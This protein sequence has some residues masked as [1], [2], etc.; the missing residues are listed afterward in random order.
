MTARRC[1]LL[2]ATALIG[3]V[4]AASAA[5]KDLTDKGEAL[6]RENCSR[7]HAIGNERFALV[8]HPI[9]LLRG[10]ASAD[11]NLDRVRVVVLLVSK[12]GRLDPWQERDSKH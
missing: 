11:D 4:G 1:A 6:V 12:H 3:A 8:G 7:C 5:D 10:D 2:I 9:E